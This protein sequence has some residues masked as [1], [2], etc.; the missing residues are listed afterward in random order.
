MTPG[1]WCLTTD[2]LS[3]GQGPSLLFPRNHQ[4]HNPLWDLYC[5]TS[6]FSQW[7]KAYSGVAGTHGWRQTRKMTAWNLFP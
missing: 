4:G 7:F 3:W 2:S 1:L 6:V 5:S